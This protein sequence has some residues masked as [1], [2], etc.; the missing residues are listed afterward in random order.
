MMAVLRVRIVQLVVVLRQYLREHGA[1]LC[2]PGG[3]RHLTFGT[4][5][6]AN[7]FLPI[8]R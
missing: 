4:A 3:W 8:S 2:A 6:A 7:V 5:A 1:A